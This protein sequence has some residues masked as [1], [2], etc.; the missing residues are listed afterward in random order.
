MPVIIEVMPY[1]ALIQS[2]KYFRLIPVSK[3][4]VNAIKTRYF[5]LIFTFNVLALYGVKKCTDAKLAL[6]LK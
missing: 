4:S 2:G 5:M 3:L 6:L 1:R